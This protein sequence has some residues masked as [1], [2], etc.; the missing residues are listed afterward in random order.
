MNPAGAR[1]RKPPPADR[2]RR[3]DRTFDHYLDGVYY[4]RRPSV[5]VGPLD[6]WK[7]GAV[8]LVEIPTDDEIHD[9]IV[10]FWVAREPA[11]AGTAWRL[12]YRL[13]WLADKPYPASNVARA[14][15]TRIGCGGQP[16][17]P[18]SKG[19]E[20]FC[21][22]FAGGPLDL[23][24]GG[25]QP[26]AVVT[27]S[28]GRISRVFTEPVPDTARWRAF[29]D[30]AAPGTDPVELRLF[31][32][33]GDRPLSET[34]LY[35]FAPGRGLRRG[36]GRLGDGSGGG[37][38]GAEGNRTPDLLIANEAL[39]QLS[40]GPDPSRA[41]GLWVPSR[42]LSRKGAPVPAARPCRLPPA[43]WGK[44]RGATGR[45]PPVP[46]RPLARAAGERLV[47]RPGPERLSPP[48]TPQP[49]AIRNVGR[50]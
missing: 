40:Y 44:A 36:G 49:P 16:G 7:D 14:V 22:E 33:L 12:R 19:V 21:V 29:F 45:E 25:E 47:S 48:R 13:H 39:S 4:D 11:R 15:A 10:A 26:L 46:R 50:R 27:A 18:R 2:A 28:G 20:K 5:W 34:W 30:L 41:C 1:R 32:R 31:L 42:P 24:G 3:R 43:A 23:L 8:Q 9:K 38:G 6:G 35:Q 37:P 17:R